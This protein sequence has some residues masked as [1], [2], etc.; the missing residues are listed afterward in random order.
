MLGTT[1]GAGEI[2]V[3]K[4]TQFLSLGIYNLVRKTGSKQINPSLLIMIKSAIK[5]RAAMD[6]ESL[7]ED[8]TSKVRTEGRKTGSHWKIRGKTPALSYH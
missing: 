4:Q 3:K 1:I 8:V 7:S 6:R 2:L 5:I